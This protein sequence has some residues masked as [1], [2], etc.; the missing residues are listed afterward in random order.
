MYHEFG[1]DEN[2]AKPI[3]N[4]AKTTFPGKDKEIIECYHDTAFVL[5]VRYCQL[6]QVQKIM[7]KLNKTFQ[8]LTMFDL[9]DVN[10]M[11]SSSMLYTVC[12]L[13]QRIQSPFQ[14][15]TVHDLIDDF[16]VQRNIHEEDESLGIVI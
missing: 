11:D 13:Y 5:T 2:I 7:K 1:I 8:D 14:D 12:T 4:Y 9:I 3:M 15:I 16:E 10:N 6:R